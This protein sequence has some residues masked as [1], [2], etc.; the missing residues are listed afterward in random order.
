M[1]IDYGPDD[2]YGDGTIPAPQEELVKKLLADMVEIPGQG[3]EMC[4]YEVSQELW[5]AVMG[6]NPSMSKHPDKPVEYVSY[7]DCNEFIEKLNALPAIVATGKTFRLP[8]DQEWVYACRAGGSVGFH[9]YNNCRLEDG[10]EISLNSPKS[11]EKV[12]WVR[13]N[14]NR[15]SHP[16][17]QK[18]PNA[19]GLYDMCGNVWEWT[20]T[21]F[22]RVLKYEIPN[23]ELRSIRGGGFDNPAIDCRLFDDYGNYIAPLKKKDYRS[24]EIGFRLVR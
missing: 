4:K 22:H 18:Q 1:P 10:S 8:T 23:S 11:T 16:V 7:L 12:A 19:F 13:Q 14:S 21:G 24:P 15:T 2:P 9:I 3:F 17:G 6:N 20:S 5:V